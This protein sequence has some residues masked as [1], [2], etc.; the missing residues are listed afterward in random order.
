MKTSIKE[1]NKLMRST[2]L[3]KTQYFYLE[4]TV[5]FG[6]DRV[7]KSFERLQLLEI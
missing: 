2:H 5:F 6:G 4:N 7:K 3:R 1:K